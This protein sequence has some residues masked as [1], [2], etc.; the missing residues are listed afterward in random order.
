ML[1]IKK[2][3]LI[4]KILKDGTPDEKN[5]DIVSL[6][7]GEVEFIC[8]KKDDGEVDYIKAKVLGFEFALWSH[9]D[10]VDLFYLN[11]SGSY[12]SKFDR[13][14]EAYKTLATALA[15]ELPKVKGV[16]FTAQ[17]IADDEGEEANDTDLDPDD[18]PV[19]DTEDRL[20]DKLQETSTELKDTKLALATCEGKVAVYESI[21]PNATQVRNVQY[22]K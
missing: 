17:E 18:A 3:N 12:I 6:T 5:A 22:S 4:K 9:L 19:E 8:V 7:V 20:L 10:T 21:T 2:E 13:I 11:D 1:M 16:T 15:Y 14:A